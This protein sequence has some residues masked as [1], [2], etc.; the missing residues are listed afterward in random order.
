MK[1]RKKE[2]NSEGKGFFG[3]MYKIIDTIIKELLKAILS[4]NKKK[5]GG[6]YYP[7]CPLYPPLI[8]I[9]VSLASIANG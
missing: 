9:L 2:I 3:G 8:D 1:K 6:W 7:L 4:H 5:G